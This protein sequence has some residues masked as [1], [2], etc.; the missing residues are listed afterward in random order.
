MKAIQNH[1]SIRIDSLY[2]DEA[3]D[4]LDEQMKLKAL[5]MLETLTLNYTSIYLVEHSEALKNMVSN[6]YEVTL[7]NGESHIAEA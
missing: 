5:R 7:T 6:R 2:F 4:G 1:H 3:T